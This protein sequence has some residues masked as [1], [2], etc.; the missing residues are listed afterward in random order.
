M[1]VIKYR[2]PDCREHL[3][4]RE[5]A[6][7]DRRNSLTATAGILPMRPHPEKVHWAQRSAEEFTVSCYDD[8]VY[9]LKTVN[10]LRG[11]VAELE[12]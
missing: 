5:Q 8:I 1:V 9:L 3:N 6:I 4:E 2:I 11:R 10:S 7:W 12:G